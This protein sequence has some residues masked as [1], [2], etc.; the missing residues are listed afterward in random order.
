MELGDDALR[1]CTSPLSPGTAARRRRTSTIVERELVADDD[2]IA[3]RLGAR[4]HDIDGLRMA[5]LRNEEGVGALVLRQALAERHRFGD[6][7]PSSS[8]EALAIS[9]PVRSHQRL[10]VEQRFEAALRDFGLVR[11]VGRVP[12]GF[13]SRLRRIGA[14]CAC[15]SSPGR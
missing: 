15:C 10:E 3:Q 7:V 14:G 13:S 6:A 4:A 9:M 12:R 1:S 2:F 8:S 11:R 5:M